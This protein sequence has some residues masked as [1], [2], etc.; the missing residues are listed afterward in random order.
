[1]G[2][3]GAREAG[4]EPAVGDRVHHGDLGRDLERVVEGRQDRARDQPGGLGPLGGGRQEDHRVGAVTAVMVEIVLDDADVAVAIAVHQ[5]DQRQALVEIDVGRLVLG[6]HVGKE[7]DPEFHRGTLAGIPRGRKARMFVY[8]TF[9]LIRHRA[10][11][12][13]HR[14]IER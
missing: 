1:M 11:R 4:L 8:K 10:C 2:Q 6:P 3:E 7:L 5:V 12:I 9:C 13:V 14:I